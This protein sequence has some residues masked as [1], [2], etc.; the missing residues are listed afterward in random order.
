MNIYNINEWANIQ[1]DMSTW[2]IEYV[3]LEL[4]SFL[5]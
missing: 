2:E 5:F 1:D 3:V 4:V